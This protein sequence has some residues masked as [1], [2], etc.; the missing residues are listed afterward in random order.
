VHDSFSKKVKYQY[1]YQPQHDVTFL[2]A[3][4][5]PNLDFEQIDVPLRHIANQ[6][7]S[8]TFRGA[9]PTSPV[10]KDL[11]LLGEVQLPNIILVFD[12]AIHTA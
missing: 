9:L 5:N 7:F 3:L 12:T 10:E 2:V 6:N 4:G 11:Q 8:S 1:H